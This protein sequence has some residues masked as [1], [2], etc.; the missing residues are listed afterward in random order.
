M[1]V[2]VSNDFSSNSFRLMAMAV[3]LIPNVDQLDLLH[4]TQQQV[5][6]H[7]T[8]MELQCL[9]ILTN[10]IRPD[11]KITISQLQDG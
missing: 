5:E 6:A 1:H 3:G 2:Q 10:N 4:M 9:M 11:S 8:H 7:V